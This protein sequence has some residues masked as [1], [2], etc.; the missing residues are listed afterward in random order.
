MKMKTPVILFLA[1]IAV[2]IFALANPLNS[3]H[4]GEE[5]KLMDTDGKTISIED[6]QPGIQYHV[7]KQGKQGAKGDAGETGPIF[8]RNH[9]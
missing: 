8:M 9:N 5:T 3:L 6:L 1:I 4:I 7:K 2:A